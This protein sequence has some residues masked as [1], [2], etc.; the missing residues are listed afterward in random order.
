MI[1]AFLL[2]IYGVPVVQLSAEL[3]CRQS[4]QV[5]EL[6][7]RAPVKEHLR[8]WEDNLAHISL[9]KNRVQP[10]LQEALSGAGGFGNAQVVIGRDGW[11]FYRPGID[12]VAGQGFLQDAHFAS[13]RRKAIKDFARRR[14]PIR[15]WRSSSFATNARGSVLGC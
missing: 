2:M 10:L 7:S 14:S 12:Y 1:A 3:L 13:R 6:F 9:V 5:F 8:E 15:A 11:L 4:P